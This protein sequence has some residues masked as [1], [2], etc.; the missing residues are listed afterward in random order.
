MLSSS[1]RMG[2]LFA[3]KEEVRAESRVQRPGRCPFHRALQIFS[4]SE[5]EKS[6]CKCGREGYLK[7]RERE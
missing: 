3:S 4:E 1:P 6:S 7:V 2:G 5:D